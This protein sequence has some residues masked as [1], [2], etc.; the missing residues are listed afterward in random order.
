MVPLARTVH[1]TRSRPRLVSIVGGLEGGCKAISPYRVVKV[2]VGTRHVARRRGSARRATSSAATSANDARH[3]PLF[4]GLLLD[5]S[6]LL[7]LLLLGVVDHGCEQ[8]QRHH[9]HRH[10]QR[11]REAR[12]AAAS[13]EA[14]G[15]NVAASREEAEAPAHTPMASS[16]SPPTP[17]ERARESLLALVSLNDLLSLVWWWIRW[18]EQR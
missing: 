13:S 11:G 12:A 7:F 1:R 16:P 10:T 9:T 5:A 4:V 14:N 15:G 8:R 3:R 6:D 2:G 18:Q 17:S